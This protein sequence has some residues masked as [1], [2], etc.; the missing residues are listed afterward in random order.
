MNVKV[1]NYPKY[2][3]IMR[4][5]SSMQSDAVLQALEGLEDKFAVE[6]T[7][8][9][10]Q[11]VEEIKELNSKFGKKILIGAGTVLTFSEEIAA[12][13]AGA[14]FI[15][16]AC[17]FTKAMIEYAKKREVVTIPGVMTPTEVFR[18]DS[19]GADII[20]VFPAV[21]IG[22]R[23]FKDIQAPLGKLRLMAVGGISEKN[24]HEFFENEAQYV[25]I[26]SNAFNKED[27][28]SLNIANLHQSL[29]NLVKKS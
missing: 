27:L 21:D 2:T 23:F 20:K 8:N 11:A 16:S 25:G 1:E 28:K 17:Q 6:V 26:G 22:P 10:H 3:I 5:Y 13:D 24:I 29:V 19:Y 15:L 18:M 12:I 4:N 7:M 14:K 9:T